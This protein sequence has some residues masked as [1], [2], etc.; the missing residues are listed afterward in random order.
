MSSAKWQQFCVSLNVQIPYIYGHFC[1]SLH[2]QNSVH[3]WDPH[4]V[5]IVPAD[6]PAPNGAGPSA[7]TVLT[8]NLDTFPSQSFSVC[9]EFCITSLDQI[10]G[11]L[12]ERR[13]SIANELELHLSCTN[14]LRWHHSWWMTSFK[15]GNKISHNPTAFQVLIWIWISVCLGQTT[16]P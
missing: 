4:F 16:E 8:T 12:Q 2:V 1:L 13:N 7:G 15:M 14:P 6:G 10:D 9:Q 3:I 11:F 5:I